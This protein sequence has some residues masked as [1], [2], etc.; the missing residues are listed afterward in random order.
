MK[1]QLS[2]CGRLFL[3]DAGRGA[4]RGVFFRE[5]G[6]GVAFSL[7]PQGIAKEVVD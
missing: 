6:E 1:K 3:W 4:F 2:R 7:L 5:R